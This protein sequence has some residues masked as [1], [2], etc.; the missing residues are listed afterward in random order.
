MT[1]LY[2]KS[3]LAFALFWII[4]YVILSGLGDSLSDT[5]GTAKLVTLPIQLAM[6]M[7][8]AGWIRRQ[9]F[10][11]E[12]GF[13][14]LNGQLSDYLYFLP[15]VLLLTANLWNGVTLNFSPLE[16]ALYIFSMLLVGFLEEVIFRGLLFK[17]LC[18]DGVKQAFLISSLTFGIGHIVNLLNGA[19]LLPTLLQV[20]YAIT[21][22]FLF[23]YL[24]YAGK[25]L[26]P[27]IITHSIFNALSAFAVEPG[28][29]SKLLSALAI[30]LITSGYALWLLKHMP[31]SRD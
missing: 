6:T 14:A 4:S 21:T 28:D 19:D 27:C 2:E 1:K 15:L 3:R 22:G 31:V 20:F 25:S 9:G 18:R 13:C 11:A 7:V 30:C 29:F 5:L 26:W 8:L 23:T 12:Y 10:Q 17:A 24:F 16:T